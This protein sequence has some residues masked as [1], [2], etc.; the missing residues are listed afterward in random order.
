MPKK[1]EFPGLNKVRRERADGSVVVHYYLR[2][3]GK[4]I[5]GRYGSKEFRDSFQRARERSEND[6]GTFAFLIEEFKASPEY[7]Q[8]ISA[9]TRKDYARY[10][11]MI[12]AKFGSLPIEALNDKRVRGDFFTWRD[13]MSANPRTADYAW[14]V[15][16]RVLQW[17][18]NRGKIGVNHALN[19][20]RLY[21]SDRVDMLW[22]PTDVGRIMSLAYPEMQYAI[23]V[24]LFIG[25]RQ[26]DLLRMPKTARQGPWMV[27][28]QGKRRKGTGAAKTIHVPIHPRLDGILD[29]MPAT[30]ATTLL[31]SRSGRPWKA[32]HFRHE[33]SALCKEAGIE[34]LHFHDMRGTTATILSELGWTPQQIAAYFGWSLETVQKILERYSA[35]T[36]KLVMSGMPKFRN[37]KGTVLQTVLE[38]LQTGGVDKKEAEG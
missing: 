26:S 27:F 23:A 7:L 19:P 30:D 4:K 9:A 17:S 38:A 3:T 10:L 24:A 5:E 14:S 33:F 8:K 31:V 36:R 29:S 35:R 32:D 25:P 37:V 16:R 22:L 20:E 12:K 13:T 11:D 15:L 28:S 18:Y 2:S 6:N 34:G 1:G 21:D